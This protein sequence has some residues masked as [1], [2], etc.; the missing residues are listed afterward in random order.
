MM[1]KLFRITFWQFQQVIR[2]WNRHGCVDLSAAFAFHSLQSI[3]PFLLLC[4]GVA[5]RIFGQADG[6]LDNILDFAEQIL[7]P[8][9]RFL[10]ANILET[11]IL[12]GRAAGLIGAIALLI[13]ASNATLSLQRGYDCLWLGLKTPPLVNKS[14]QWHLSDL[15]LQRFRAIFGALLLAFL[16]LINQLTTPFK[17]IWQSIW[18]SLGSFS[19]VIPEIWQIPARSAASVISSWLALLFGVLIFLGYLPRKRPPI[20]YLWIGSFLISSALTLLNPLLGRL[21]IW[22]S[23]RFMAYGLVGGVIVLNLWVWLIGL[24]LYFGMAW[25][26]VLAK[27]NRVV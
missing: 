13:T 19:L 9:S 7:P 20:R 6:A 12:Q 11:L 25:T 8:G 27:I 10:F 16:L 23:S 1:K 14:W 17:L 24:I 4:F 26:V 5:A 15:I 22:L 21:L 2:L 3:F 18:A